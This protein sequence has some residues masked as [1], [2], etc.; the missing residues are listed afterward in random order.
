[1]LERVASAGGHLR[2]TNLE[3]SELA[4]W[5]H[6]ARAAQLRLWRTGSARLRRRTNGTTLWIPVTG[7]SASP[8][9]TVAKEAAERDRREGTPPT[10]AGILPAGPFGCRQSCLFSPIPLIVETREGMARRD[11]DRWRPYGHRVFVQDWIPDVPRQKTGRMLRIWQ[12]IVD[13]AAFRDGGRRSG[14]G[15]SRGSPSRLNHCRP[16]RDDRVG[17]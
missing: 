12:G 7:P 6:A 3:V 10:D 2:L 5:R 14:A 13:E 4:A 15:I 1:V 11:A 17:G 9:P 8:K 16:S